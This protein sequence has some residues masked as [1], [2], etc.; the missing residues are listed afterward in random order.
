MIYFLVN[1]SY[2]YFDVKCHLSDEVFPNIINVPHNISLN[3][4]DEV[5]KI[6]TIQSPF[7]SKKWMLILPVLGVVYKINK[8]FKPTKD[9]VL[10][11]YTEYDPVNNYIVHKFKKAGAK[12]FLIEDGGVAG[13]VN[14]RLNMDIRVKLKNRFKELFIWLF[15]ERTKV[16]IRDIDS[17]S[18]MQLTDNYIDGLIYYKPITSNRD[19]N[20]H[21]L[22]R[23]RIK[24]HNTENHII[25]FDQQWKYFYETYDK[26]I[27]DLIDI[28]R[29]HTNNFIK[30]YFKFHPREKEENIKRIM[31]DISKANLAVNYIRSKEPIE[32][33][34]NKYN[35]KF[36]SSICTSALLTL[37]EIGVQPIF[38]YKILKFESKVIKI[39]DI[40]LKELGYKFIFNLEDIN[41]SYISGIKKN[42][43]D[44]KLI[45]FIENI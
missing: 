32:V 2:H 21:I 14:N 9:D 28:L 43:S 33:I 11:F 34:I 26:Y 45:D 42:Y 41:L 27:I 4:T 13:Y 23:N 17:L 8:L 29:S 25:F 30:V 38:L 24:I 39:M 16:R 5:N 44:K 22:K 3:K 18:K 20:I 6:F 35:I 19:I 10:F 31:N 1:N 36:S 40:I 37:T 15:F 7:K 12:I